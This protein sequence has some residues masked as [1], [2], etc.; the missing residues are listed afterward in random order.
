MSATF[1][2]TFADLADSVRHYRI[3]AYTGWQDIRQR[4][5]RSTLGPLWLTLSMGVMVGG[6]GVL[7]STLFRM[8]LQ[9]YIP[10]FCVS[11]L[12][13]TLVSSIIVDSCYAF[14]SA[15]QLI[16]HMKLP[17]TAH[18]LRIIWRNTIVFLH[19]ITL[20][21]VI[22]FIFGLSPW[23]TLPFLI[24][25]FL[26]WAVT[27]LSIGILLG[28]ICARFRDVPQIVLSLIQILLFFSPILWKPSLLNGKHAFL[29]NW[30]P[31]FQFMEIVRG[32]MLGYAP[33]IGTW[34]FCV[35]ATALM[36]GGALLMFKRFRNRIPYWV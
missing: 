14:T 16:K 25:A 11:I 6:V 8:Q 7:Y 9:E 29:V 33:P 12:C 5:R 3:W 28:M 20:Y 19:H 10:Y 17:Y 18:V 34:I 4:Y 26:L 23:T 22:V 36:A 31:V 24:P 1:P 15:E 2:A 21:I 13:W 32:P 35:I 30:N 27:A